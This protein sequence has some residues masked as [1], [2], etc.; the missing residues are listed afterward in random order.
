[1]KDKK[2]IQIPHSVRGRV[3]GKQGATIQ[4]ISKKTGARI[5][6]SKQEAAD[7]LEDDDDSATVDVTIEGDPFAVEMARQDIMKIVDEHTSSLTQRLKHIPA[8]Y[9]PFLA[10]PH[11]ARINELEQANDLRVQIPHYH[12]WSEQAP[13]QAPANRQ[14]ASFAPQAGLPIQLAGDRKAVAEARAQLDRQVQE[15]QRQLTLEQLAIERGRHQFI[16]GDKG[17]SMHDFLA[18][19]GCAVILPPD[20]ND[21]EELTIVGPPER[22][23]E[24]IDKIMDLAASMHS[25]AVDVAKQH[26]NAPR[27]AQAHARDLMRYLQQ[28]QAMEQIEG[29]YDARIVPDSTAGFQI[30]ARDPKNAMKAR[31]DMMNLISGHP[32]TRFSPMDVDP[33]YHQHLRQQAA[34]QIRDQYGVHVVVPEEFDEAPQV[35]L[36]Y[37]GPESPPSYEFPRRQP[38]ASDAQNFQKALQEAQQHLLGLMGGQQDITSK[39]VDAP[40]KFHDKIRRHVDRHQQGLPS[41]Q[42]PVQ[43]LYGGPRTQVPRRAPAPSLSMRGPSDAVDALTQ[44]LL[45]FIE[46]EKQDELERGFTL[47]FDF[48]QKFANILIGRKGENI[49]KLREEFDVD[50]QL[51][52]GK[53]EIKGPEA[54]ANACKAHIISMAKKLEDEASYVLNIPPQFHRDLIGAQGSQV[55]RLQD[56]YNVRVNFPRTRQAADDE[57]SNADGDTAPSRRN[58]QAPNEVMVKGP[59]R[60]ADEC[61]DELLSLL[62]YLKDNSHTATVSVAQN[63]LPS[64]IGSGGREMEALRLE[65]GAQID[66]PGSRDAVDP[67]GRA[68]IRLKGSKAAVENAKKLLEQRAKAFDDTITRNLEIDRKYHRNIIGSQGKGRLPYSQ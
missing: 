40:V 33:F 3:V 18:E 39:D 48:P 43:V 28:R 24:G 21:S 52:E 36:V 47:E 34:S 1:M 30:Y 66:V 50:I 9:Y 59:K 2:E 63:Q 7:I 49:N 4:A 27:G 56:R 16:V 6:I 12:T 62:Q 35:L 58:N 37:E 13:P 51:N 29:T 41:D 42:I 31:A 45:A 65:T 55:N 11:N 17:Y 32:P 54:K 26:P 5:N 64:L 10:G 44:S 61:R 53:C 68:E 46:Q 67:S 14:P 20:S 60:G 23:Q 25:S 22:L 8:E 15:L 19:T 57:A 38:S